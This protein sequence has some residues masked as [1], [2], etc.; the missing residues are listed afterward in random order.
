MVNLLFST[1]GRITRWKFWL[2]YLPILFGTAPLIILIERYAENNPL[3]L[4]LVL[5][6]YVWIAFCLAAKRLHDAD[7][8]A[9]NAAFILLVPFIAAIIIGVIPGTNGKN[10]FGPGRF[11]DQP[12]AALV[13]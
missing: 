11:T 4:L 2:A 13:I 8:H 10:R 5:L 1:T 3:L 9:G 7:V 12:R 6:L